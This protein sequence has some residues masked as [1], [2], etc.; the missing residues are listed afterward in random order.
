MTY[1]SPSRVVQ[2]SR[3]RITSRVFILRLNN[4]QFTWLSHLNTSDD[5]FITKANLGCSV[6]IRPAA[7]LIMAYELSQSIFELRSKIYFSKSSSHHHSGRLLEQ[8]FLSIFKL[9]NLTHFVVYVVS[10]KPASPTG[11]QL[12][13]YWEKLSQA[14]TQTNNF[15]VQTNKRSAFEDPLTL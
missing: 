11:K 14:R 6:I 15:I 5:V 8:V 1:F 13:T 3:D 4:W 7:H 2:D 12:I 9:N 10:R